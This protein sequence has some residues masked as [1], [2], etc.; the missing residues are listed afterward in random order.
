MTVGQ[1]KELLAQAYD[2]TEVYILQA[3]YDDQPDWFDPMVLIMDDGCIGLVPE[4][5]QHL[6]GTKFGMVE[7]KP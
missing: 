6:K 5:A 2:G 7:V 3:T 1:L 4:T